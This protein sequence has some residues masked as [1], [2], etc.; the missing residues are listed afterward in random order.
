MNKTSLPRV[1]FFR[2]LVNP[3]AGSNGGN[4]K[5]RDCYNHLETSPRYQPRVFFHP[6]TVWP[7]ETY[8]HHWADLRQSSLKNWKIKADDLLFFSGHD[9][10][11]LSEEQRR[12]PPAP[13]INIVQPRH[14]RKQDARR[15]FLKYPAIRIAKSEHG[16]AILRRHGLNGPLFVIPDAI[17]LAALPTLP[18]RKDIDIL[19]PGLKQPEFARQLYA[20]LAAWNEREGLELKIHLQLPPKLPRRE[21][22]LHL[23]AR[24]KCIACVPLEAARG[25]EGFYL[26][27][28]EAMALQTLV[29]CPHAVGNVDHCLDGVNCLVPAF[30]V[31][32]ISEKVQM[33]WRLPAAK[34]AALIE[35]GLRTAQKHRIEEERAATLSLVHRARQ[36]WSQAE[37]FSPPMV[38]ENW[39]AKGRRFLG[40]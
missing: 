26:P 4:L 33:A 27:A 31:E 11:V 40:W 36:L 28:L 5:L 24:A 30:T 21:D 25:S 19:I 3:G 23:V 32:A 18:D 14:A 15:E 34:K 16:A 39:W 13:I 1:L 17:D 7:A 6:D 38:D 22:F 10:Q 20:R 29:V 12:Q 2:R 8:G 35:G 9:W 37:L